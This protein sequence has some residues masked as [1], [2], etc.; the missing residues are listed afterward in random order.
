VLTISVD[1]DENVARIVRS[2]DAI[3]VLGLAFQKEDNFSEVA[4]SGTAPTINNLDTIRFEAPKAA[5]D[6][7]GEVDLSHGVFAPGATNEGDG[8]SE[9]EVQMNLLGDNS[10]ASIYGTG[11]ADSFVLGRNGAVA[12]ANLNPVQD[13]G[14]PDV[15]VTGISDAPFVEG[16]A[17]NDRITLNGGPAATLSSARRQTAGAARTGSRALRGRTCCSAAREATRSTP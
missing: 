9:I 12:G 13:G 15:D 6:V 16:N 5:D 7:F 3:R 14:S 4:C 10:S 11:G 2:G 1:D 17:G 8:S